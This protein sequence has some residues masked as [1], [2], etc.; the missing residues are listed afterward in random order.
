P[1]TE[2]QAPLSCSAPAGGLCSRLK[3]ER[4]QSGRSPLAR[5][6]NGRPATLA[7]IAADAR[8]RGTRTQEGSTR[9]VGGPTGGPRVGACLAPGRSGPLRTALPPDGRPPLRG[10]RRPDGE[11][12]RGPRPAEPPPAGRP[13][14]GPAG[15]VEGPGVGPG[16]RRGWRR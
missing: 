12:R 9:R 11:Y 16:R 10:A 2:S 7:G 5:G 8:G 14:A 4:T 6:S 1:V 13:R 3:A 15:T